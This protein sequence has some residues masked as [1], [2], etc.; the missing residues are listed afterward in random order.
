M[1]PIAWVKSFTTPTGKSARVFATT[2]GASQDLAN[3]GVRRMLVNACYWAQGLENA[4]PARCDVAIVGSY[5][6]HPF[7]FG[8]FIKGVK[9]AEHALKQ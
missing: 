6:P 4:I 2:M 3:E 5:E 8:T 1:M 7:G 9:P